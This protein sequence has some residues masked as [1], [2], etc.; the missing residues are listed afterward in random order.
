MPR[1]ASGSVF[2]SKGSYFARVTVGP[3][4]RKA[5]R[6]PSIRSED[7]ARERA[8]A[9]AQLAADLRAAEVAREL[10]VRLVG[11]AAEA[12]T[13]AELG[14]VLETGRRVAAGELRPRPTNATTFRELGELWTSGELH[15]RWPDHVR[16]KRTAHRDAALLEA[17]VYP[18]VGSVRLVD[19]TLEHAETVMRALP[20]MERATRRQYAQVIA[21]V[22]T[23]AAYPARVIAR[24]PL[25]R[26][27][28]PPVRTT[29]AKSY[30]YPAEDRALLACAAVPLGLRVLYGFLAREGMRAG[31]ACGLQ[32]RDV[33]FVVG[34]VRLDTNKTDDPRTWALDP[35]SCARSP[36][37]TSCVAG[38]APTS[39]SSRSS[40]PTRGTPR[41]PSVA[42]WRPPASPGPSSSR[43]APRGCA[44]GSTT[45][46]A[47][48]SPSRSRTAARRPGS[49]IGR[50]TSRA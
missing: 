42:T 10:V 49:P 6:L 47:P 36:A 2:F 34:T 45:C 40:A 38:R 48:S 16:A 18:I 21:R 12:R 9:L 41:G 4:V 44:C 28:V 29:K 13:S 7:A 30:L 3:R 23:L 5:F 11:A 32:W 37:G 22:L 31:E 24:S 46:A 8:D 26:G 17:R 14:E 20:K 39:S 50:G 33:D 43:R 19:F 35:V 1:R 27:F 15:R 25:P